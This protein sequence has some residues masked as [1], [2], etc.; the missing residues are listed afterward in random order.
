MYALRYAPEELPTGFFTEEEYFKNTG[1]RTR[2]SLIEATLHDDPV[3]PEADDHTMTVSE[4]LNA[5]QLLDVLKRDLGVGSE[6]W[7]D[8]SNQIGSS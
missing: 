2:A 4:G 5:E 3:V 6:I 1:G 8:R 7:N